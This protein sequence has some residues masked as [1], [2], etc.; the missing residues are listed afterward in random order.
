LRHYSRH[1]GLPCL[2]NAC[3][4]ADTAD[5]EGRQLALPASASSSRGAAATVAATCAQPVRLRQSL[6]RLIA[7]RETAATDVAWFAAYGCL[8]AAL[9][10]DRSFRASQ[11]QPTSATRSNVAARA[12]PDHHGL[13]DAT[14]RSRCREVGLTEEE[15][16]YAIVMR[17]YQRPAGVIGSL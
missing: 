4:R 2:R 14:A 16:T 10:A 13:P 6:P 11:Y 5:L 1:A 17:Q 15:S 7:G 9:K 12:A 3:R 8:G